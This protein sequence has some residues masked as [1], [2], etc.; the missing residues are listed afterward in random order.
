MRYALNILDMSVLK[1][2]AALYLSTTLSARLELVLPGMWIRRD[3]DVGVI[4]FT[5][6]CCL[7]GCDWQVGEEFL[8]PRFQSSF[9]TPR[10]L[11][12]N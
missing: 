5:F 3:T 6:F 11:Y 4:Q 8:E 10:M 9:M 1:R 12:L 2:L 7:V